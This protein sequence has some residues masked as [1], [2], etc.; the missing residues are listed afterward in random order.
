MAVL[1]MYKV[2]SCETP[3]NR[4]GW[5]EAVK[6]KAR[7]ATMRFLRQIWGLSLRDKN[8][9]S[10]AYC[11]TPPGDRFAFGERLFRFS[12]FARG[13]RAAIV[14]QARKDLAE[15]PA[16]IFIPFG[17]GMRFANHGAGAAE[18]SM[19][20]LAAMHSSQPSSRLNA[21]VVLTR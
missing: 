3:P 17:R 9:S 12:R 7:E 13:R 16:P 15:L 6:L 11:L 10:V 21:I 19:E 14:M 4:V 1:P 5:S 18:C 20:S 8:S 2:I